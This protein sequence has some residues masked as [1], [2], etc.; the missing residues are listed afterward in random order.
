MTND[1][2]Y[3]AL[4][5]NDYNWYWS[6]SMMEP[7]SLNT[8]QA[9]PTSYNAGSPKRIL[10]LLKCSNVGTVK[11]LEFGGRFN[12]EALIAAGRSDCN[13]TTG[14]VAATRGLKRA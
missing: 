7:R 12:S 8:Q 4:L 6:T 13:L 11:S 10:G 2:R 14:S 1:D 3:N 9:F 5:K